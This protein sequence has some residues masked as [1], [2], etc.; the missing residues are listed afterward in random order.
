MTLDAAGSDLE[1]VAVDT[2]EKYGAIY[3]DIGRRVPAVDKA[4]R[5]LGWKATTSAEEG[6]A[7]T[8][9]WARETPWYLALRP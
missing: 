5:V 3:E 1:P 9:A 7:K 6:I 4:E 2:T 8:V